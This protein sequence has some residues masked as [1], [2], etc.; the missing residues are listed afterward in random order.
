[1]HSECSTSEKKK[2]VDAIWLLMED[3]MFKILHVLFSSI[4]C[5][6]AIITGVIG[7]QTVNREISR[8]CYRC[9]AKIPSAGKMP[10]ITIIAHK[11]IVLLLNFI[12]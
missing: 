2:D 7:S 12:S 4:Q 1:M 3:N 10:N 9:I 8:L 11:H 6:C 5:H